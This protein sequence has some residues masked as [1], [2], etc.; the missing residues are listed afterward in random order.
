M[1]Q[2]FPISLM[3]TLRME[4]GFSNDPH[5][6]GGPTNQGIT[7]IEFQNFE[8]DPS[9][10]VSDLKAIDD[11]TVSAIYMQDYWYPSFAP[12]LPDGIDC[13]VFDMGVNAGVSRSV[14]QLQQAVGVKEDGIVG[15]KTLSAIAVYNPDHLLMR[16]EVIQKA[17]YRSLSNFQYF[18][19]GWLN[20]CYARYNQAM[21]M[22]AH[23]PSAKAL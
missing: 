21:A 18:G 9:L 4:G 23:G 19:R 12:M 5:D 15:P 17:Y 7:L 2:N 8:G 14:R 6:P 13:S 1:N 10:T 20:R 3:F 16:L 22:V 11:G